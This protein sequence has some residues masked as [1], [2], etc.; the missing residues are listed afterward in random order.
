MKKLIQ[1]SIAIISISIL[2][3]CAT[4]IKQEA[5]VA[6]TGFKDRL[7]QAQSLSTK[8]PNQAIMIL[9][10]LLKNYEENSLTDDALFL[11]GTV[12]EK[13]GNTESAIKAF[14]RILTSK[15]S[16]P[17][18][19]RTVIKLYKIYMSFGDERKALSA[20][21]YVSRNELI[22]Q[23]RLFEIEKYRAPLLLKKEKYISYLESSANL[24]RKN[25]DQSFRK[26][27]FN[28]SISI[29]KIKLIGPENKRILNNEKLTLF[30][31]QA[32]LNL[33]EYHFE[34][35]RA[36][37]ALV[38]LETY[39]SLF[40]NNYYQSQ[41][42]DLIQR[43]KTY[44]SANNRT[45]GVL[46]PLSGRYQDIGQK[47]LQGLQFSL[48]VWNPQNGGKEPIRMVVLD[49]EAKPE[50]MELAF[51]EMIK[52]DR[53]VV[54]VGGLVGK[55]AETLVQKSEEFKVPSIILSQK[56]G[57]VENSKYSF[58]SS[59]PLSEYTNYIAKLAIETLN[60]KTASILHSE[61]GFSKTYAQSFSNSFEKYGGKIV[62]VIPYDKNE[63]G[64][65]PLAIKTLAQLNTVGD[66][67]E[68]YT[69]AYNKWKEDNKN[70][71]TRDEPAI[72]ELLPP[73][74]ESELL[75]ISDGPKN[76][77]LIASTLAYFDI[78][79]LPLFGPHLWN[80][81]SF[82]T[83][84]QRFIEDAVFAHSYFEPEVLNSKC[85]SFYKQMYEKPLDVYSYK[86]LEAGTVLN[87]I[88]N[89]TKI[90]SRSDMVYALSK[91]TK[92]NDFC[93]PKGLVRMNH[94]YFSPV[95]PLTVKSKK[96]TIFDPATYSKV[97]DKNSDFE[98]KSPEL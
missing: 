31:P 49:T 71:R 29:M 36:D 16:S 78:E 44:E 34:S 19:G 69:E 83:R 98:D 27:Q 15:Y 13:Q 25:T 91:T 4:S 1:L 14:R 77:G 95:T 38:V 41:K 12:L 26:Q 48:R 9:D 92:I 76:G 43:A 28:K 5:T 80:N 62:S 61:K 21:D 23:S 20:L 89:E 59:Q 64:S 97:S 2:V 10:D 45:I 87:S 70:R 50:Q 32:A 22:D 52:K 74:V 33:A 82:I 51:E 18:D 65:I 93:F 40:T 72:E 57:L 7:I 47:I 53:P 79:D 6:P 60:L 75:F 55:T 37:R 63:R 56:E 46:I 11:M 81:S 8:N 86:G 30:H 42:I 3:S 68:E 58:Q 90:D 39:S 94:N 73:K 66:R 24:I 84:G 35:G 17:L 54:F 67:K 85:N 88:L 96:I